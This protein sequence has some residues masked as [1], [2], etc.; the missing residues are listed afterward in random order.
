MFYERES[1]EKSCE[2]KVEKR[3][4]NIFYDEPRKKGIKIEVFLMISLFVSAEIYGH[5]VGSKIFI[6]CVLSGFILP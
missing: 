1:E 2:V 3:S 5:R 6:V 4:E